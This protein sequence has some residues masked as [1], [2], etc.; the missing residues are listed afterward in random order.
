MDTP[1]HSCWKQFRASGSHRNPLS[2]AGRALIIVVAGLLATSFLTDPALAEEPTFYTVRWGDSL[3]QIAIQTGSTVKAIMSANNLQG[4]SIYDGQ[5]LIIPVLPG[6]IYSVLR[7]DTLVLLA[8]RH[9]TSVA[10]I[11][12]ANRLA[13]TTI[14]AGQRLALPSASSPFHPPDAPAWGATGHQHVARRGN[15]AIMLAAEHGTSLLALMALNN[16]TSTV[17]FAGQE[18]TFPPSCATPARHELGGLAELA[19]PSDHYGITGSL[20]APGHRGIDIGSPSGSAV[21]AASSG[22]VAYRGWADW[23]YGVVVVLSHAQ[24]WQTLYAHLSEGLPSCGDHVRQ[25]DI[26]GFSGSSGNTSG[27]H[28]HF[29]TLFRG[30]HVNPLGHVVSRVDDQAYNRE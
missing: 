21:Y 19:W 3:N 9:G 27:P 7:G 29:E 5:H 1:H 17:V 8:D 16:M 24:G 12:R 25:G 13:T 26:I 14:F 15:S 11:M 20:F 23:G 6:E 30:R 22:H 2:W 10:S 28:L 4:S 18:L